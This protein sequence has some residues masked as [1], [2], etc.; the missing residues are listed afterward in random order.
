[1]KSDSKN[2]ERVSVVIPLYNERDN[3]ANVLKELKVVADDPD[4]RIHEIIVVD[5]GSTD[6][7][8]EKVKMF[9]DALLIVHPENRG[10]G[11]ALKTGI[12]HANGEIIVTLDA[13]GQHDPGEVKKL[14]NS[15]EGY[16]MCVG[17]RTDNK[18]IPII[19]L[20]GKWVLHK[21][22]NYLLGRKIPDFNAGFRAIRREVVDRY[23]HVCPNG[24]SFSTTITMILI[25]EGY[26]VKFIPTKFRKRTSSVSKVSA[27]SGLSVLLLIFRIIMLFNPLKIFGPIALV[28]GMLGLWFLTMDLYMKNIHDI[29]ILLIVVATVI[30]LFGL[31]ADQI[32]HIRKERY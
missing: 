18:S 8:S 16:E 22:V 29:T 1:M 25:S 6:E 17:Y 14:I 2:N 21:L 4:N 11:A 31:I 26:F 12:R 30:F 27:L 23:L 5:D 3:I 24:Y 19:R 10:Y 32:A 7:S 13:D 9:P 20:P 15:M 28:I